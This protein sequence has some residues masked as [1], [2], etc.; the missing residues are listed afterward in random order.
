[1]AIVA[2]LGGAFGACVGVAAAVTAVIP[3]TALWMSPIVCRSG[4]DMAYNTSHYGYKPGQSGTSVSFQCVS[5]G[6]Y[7]DVND[8]AVFAL[9]SLLTAVVLGVALAVGGLLWRRS[10]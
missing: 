5:N 10:H 2:V 4:Y 8:F 7:Y 9:Q 1:V 6:D 3:S